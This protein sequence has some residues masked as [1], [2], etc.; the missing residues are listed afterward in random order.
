MPASCVTVQIGQCGTQL[1]ACVLDRLNAEAQHENDAEYFFRRGK[2]GERVA[3]AVLV[4]TEPR[5]V[6]AMEGGERDDQK[7]VYGASNR[8]LCDA[9]LQGCANNWA[10]GYRTKEENVA[11]AA[12]VVRREMERSDRV[13]ALLSFAAGAGGTGSGLGCAFHSCF[14]DD[15]PKIRPL[16]CVV[17]PDKQGDVAV[18]SYNATLTLNHLSKDAKR[19]GGGLCLLSNELAK[20]MCV[21]VFRVERPTFDHLN[22]VFATL[23][24]GNLLPYM[25][26]GQRKGLGSTLAHCCAGRLRYLTP[27]AAPLYER[28]SNA[29]F[30]QNLWP[31]VCGE[32]TRRAKF[33]AEPILRADEKP[34]IDRS[35]PSKASVCAGLVVGR[36]VGGDKACAGIAVPGP[37]GAPGFKYG[38]SPHASRIAPRAAFLFAN[39]SAVTPVLRHIESRCSAMLEF[40]AYVHH[41]EKYGTTAA[42]LEAA[43]ASLRAQIADYDGLAPSVASVTGGVAGL[44]LP[45]PPP[46]CADDDRRAA[47]RAYDADVGPLPPEC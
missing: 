20:Q 42:D 18:G 29:A 31:G 5:V 36:G 38:N 26:D 10:K 7:W 12:D 43:L 23:L 32:L 2:Q 47:E 37:A 28:A 14:S 16:H 45:P 33:L 1:G 34:P 6:G 40:R 25:I 44:A 30:D 22:D 17:L 8:V 19:R 46:R 4:D 39:S 9:G 24:A 11:R 3:R 21:H 13:D 27:Y 41:Y 35:P 15:H